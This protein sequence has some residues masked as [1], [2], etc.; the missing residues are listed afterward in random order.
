MFTSS[1]YTQRGRDYLL[2]FW[3]ILLPDTIIGWNCFLSAH[4]ICYPTLNMLAVNLIVRP[5]YVMSHSCCFSDSVFVSVQFDYDMSLCRY[6]FFLPRVVQASLMCVL[7]FSSNLG[8]FQQLSLQN[9][10][11]HM[12]VCLIVFHRSFRFFSLLILFSP[13]SD[14]VIF[15]DLF[16]NLLIL[17][18]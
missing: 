10:F 1:T 2:C 3:R 7:I 14:L 12:L 16:S 5:F 13:P 18:P 4:R 6:E 8:D 9:F 15:V 11:F 17:L